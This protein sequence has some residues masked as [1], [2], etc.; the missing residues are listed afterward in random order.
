MSNRIDYTKM[1]LGSVCRRWSYRKKDGTEGIGQSKIEKCP[2]C[3]R[4]GEHMMRPVLK[5]MEAHEY[6]HAG[7]VVMGMFN[8]ITDSC[9]VIVAYPQPKE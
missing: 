1:R 4:K 7:E 2:K 5:T 8:R 6:H 3:G 9:C